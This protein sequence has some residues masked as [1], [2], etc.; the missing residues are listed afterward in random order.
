MH[1]LVDA[2]ADL[3]ELGV[4]FSD[5]MADGPVIQHANERA[6]ARGVG[7]ARD[8]R[9]RARVPHARCD[10][11]G[12]ADGLSESD[13]D[14]RHR[15]FRARG[16]RS[17]RRW[18]PAGRLPGRGDRHDRADP[19]G[20]PGAHLPRRADDRARRGSP[21]SAPRPKVS[22]TTCPSPASPAPTGSAWTTSTPASQASSV[23]R[24]R[25]SRSVSACATRL[26]QRRSAHSPMRS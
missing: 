22:Y 5:P 26:R 17:R 15:A 3:I 18:R 7:L 16:A 11:A 21:R 9:V 23:R 13:R 24:R 10:D 1:A 19:R 12:R 25:R 6:L 8:A 14:P 4:P 2:G 20:G